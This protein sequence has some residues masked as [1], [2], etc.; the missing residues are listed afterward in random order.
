MDCRSISQKFKLGLAFC[1]PIK[2]F[3]SNWDGRMLLFDG[4]PS[5]DARCQL[6]LPLA[7]DWWRGYQC[8]RGSSGA[9]DVS[10]LH[11]RDL[12]L[13]VLPLLSFVLLLVAGLSKSGVFSSSFSSPS[14]RCCRAHFPDIFAFLINNC[15]ICV[16]WVLICSNVQT[17]EHFSVFIFYFVVPLFTSCLQASGISC[18]ASSAP[19]LLLYYAA[20]CSLS[21]WDSCSNSSDY[22]SRSLLLPLFWRTA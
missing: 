10:S 12:S 3:P 11:P 20:V 5:I 19:L 22:Y 16:W 2:S 7:I 1:P 15:E 17:P 9:P 14:S 4:V 21:V 6:F 18:R 13:W 8:Q